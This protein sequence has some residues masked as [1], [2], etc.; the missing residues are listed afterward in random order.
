MVEMDTSEDVSISKRN[1]DVEDLVPHVSVS[2]VSDGEVMR[3]MELR[4]IFSES[5]EEHE[6]EDE[7]VAIVK[8]DE[9]VFSAEE[10][11]LHVGKIYEIPRS[12]RTVNVDHRERFKTFIRTQG[13]E[14]ICGLVVVT[15]RRL[16]PSNSEDI[17]QLFDG[18]AHGHGVLGQNL[19][20]SLVDGRHCSET[21]KELSESD[22]PNQWKSTGSR[23]LLLTMPNGIVM[24]PRRIVLH[25]R[26]CK[27]TDD[28][29]FSN[30]FYA[31]GEV[32]FNV[33][34]DCRD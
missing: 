6:H 25:G 17:T 20:V 12:L 4:P 30:F 28:L 3:P 19:Q 33:C 18:T 13:F 22:E 15:P 9:N 31:Y 2:G 32:H 21:P 27:N 1:I 7:K 11:I 23:V 5:A 29:V 10:R 34:T 24:S 26:F 14:Y 8:F 16:V